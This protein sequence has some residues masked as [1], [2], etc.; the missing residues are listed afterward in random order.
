MPVDSW[1]GARVL[2]CGLCLGMLP[3]SAALA[4]GVLDQGA[5]LARQGAFIAAFEWLDVHEPQRAGEP[6]FDAAMGRA[7]FAA[8]QYTRAVMAWERVVLAQP[9][10]LD[11]QLALAQALYAVGDKRGVLAL[12]DAVREQAIPVDAALDIDQFLFSFDR[13][14]HAGASTVK[15]SVEMTVGHDSNANAGP[16]SAVLAS[17]VPGTPAWTLAPAAQAMSAGFGSALAVVR[18][19]YVLDARWSLVGAA[20]GS[21]LRHARGA[22]SWDNTQLDASAG[23]AWRVERHEV[24]VSGLGGYQALD[25]ERL[26]A[27]AG[28][29]GEWIYR[30]DGFRQWSGFVQ[31]LALRYPSQAMRDARRSIAGASYA[32]VLRNGAL[33]YGA[34]YAGRESPDAMGSEPLGHHVAGWRLGG[35]YPL[36]RRFG[37]FAALEGERRNYGATDPFFAVQRRDRQRSLALGLSWVPA[38]EWRITPQLA[39][40]HN[41]SSVPVSQ[42]AR[43]VFSVAVRREF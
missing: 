43:R 27:M 22:R 14:D 9:D 5:L 33:L 21:V 8:G 1:V 17:P 13:A 2:V 25:G 24:V 10:N 3:C 19:R 40:V 42:Y 32:Q 29:Q 20:S 35:Q 4:D 26:R 16:A 30:T 15:A 11:A 7:A 31:L 39:W 38:P 34:L 37:V 18:G 28:L 12:S 23:L 36:T 41:D 6:E